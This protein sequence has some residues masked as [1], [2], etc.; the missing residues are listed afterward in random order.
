MFALTALALVIVLGCVFN[1]DGAFFVRQTHA[2]TLWALAGYGLLAC[3][4]T[5]VIVAG[6]IDL[7]VGSV[8]ALV[9]VVFAT[10]VMKRDMSAVYAIP[11]SVLVGAAAGMM[12]GVLTGFF[13][14]QAFIAT[15]AMMAFARGLAKYVCQ[16]VAEG[17]KITEYPTPR[18]MEMLNTHLQVGGVKIALSVVVLV[19]CAVL[20]LV[21]L[22][23][24]VFGMRVYS[25]GDNENAARVAG[26]PVKWTKLLA[27]GYSGLMAGV[28]GV[29]FSAIERQGNPDGGVGYELTAIAMVVIGG[30]ALAGGRGGVML[31]VLGMLTIG[32]LR[33]ILDLNAIETHMQLMI[34]GVII[35][36]AVVAP[37]LSAR[38]AQRLRGST[39]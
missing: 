24:T 25:V 37:G 9:G 29:L 12:S 21:I 18:A 17:A 20:T 27:Y 1:A 15:L 30:T 7:S 5:V 2:D 36:L 31:T 4:M 13:G 22:R 8:V 3:G 11:I 19:A 23:L 10:L 16:A 28:A 39:A 32:Y 26:L 14:L 38:A 6:G 34:T 33:K 35:V